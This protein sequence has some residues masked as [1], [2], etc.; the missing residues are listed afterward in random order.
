MK[1][2]RSTSDIIFRAFLYHRALA[3]CTSLSSWIWSTHI[4]PLHKRPT[5]VPT[6]FYFFFIA[7][8]NFRHVFCNPP[9]LNYTTL[10][11]SLYLDH[12]CMIWSQT[13]FYNLHTFPLTHPNTSFFFFSL[14]LGRKPILSQL[15]FWRR[16]WSTV[17]VVFS[18]LS[19]GRIGQEMNLFS[20]CSKAKKFISHTIE[21]DHLS[22]LSKNECRNL[23]KI[24]QKI[25]EGTRLGLGEG[26]TL[27]PHLLHTLL[28]IW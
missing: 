15:L 13:I 24:K 9:H 10:V 20:Y 16:V 5:L 3:F 14:R 22:N 27:F 18:I 8:R 6:L 25:S 2:L 12:P 17:A 7:F 23:Q 11:A 4:A 19:I 21:L 1:F 28:Y 26:P